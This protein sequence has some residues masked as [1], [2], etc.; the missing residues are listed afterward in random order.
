MSASL[1][2]EFAEHLGDV[3][4]RHAGR[5][6]AEL[7]ELWRIGLEREAIVTVAYRH[8]RIGQRLAKMPLDDDARAVIARAVRWAWRDEQ[9]HALWIRGAHMKW[10]EAAVAVAAETRGR[11]G[12]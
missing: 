8:D 2:A 9:A 3:A 6:R 1:I 4:R 11:I 10:N 5:P 12:G 7:D